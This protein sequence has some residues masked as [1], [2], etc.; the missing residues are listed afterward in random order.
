M[1]NDFT[2]NINLQDSTGN[3]NLQDSTRNINLQDAIFYYNFGKIFFPQKKDLEFICSISHPN[4]KSVVKKGLTWA[5]R[6]HTK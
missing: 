5:F 1:Y 2:R 4:G 6:K 3:I